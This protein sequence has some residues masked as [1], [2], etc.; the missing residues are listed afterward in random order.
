MRI[1]LSG[2]SGFIGSALKEQ[3]R[4]HTVVPLVR[5]APEGDEIPWNPELGK[6]D[7]AAI[8]G[9]DAFINL[10]GHDVSAGRW[11]A[12]QK[13]LIRESRT[14]TTA[15]LAGTAARLSSPPKVLIN[16]S[17]IGYYGSRGAEELTEESA[18]GT[19]FLAGVCREWEEAARVFPGRL[20]LP[21]FSV[22]LHRSG[23]ALRKMLFPFRL[24]LGGVIGDGNQYL[25]WISLSDTVRVV[26][27]CLANEKLSGPINMAAPEPVMNREFTA[28][29]GKV[30]RRPTI[31]PLPAFG[32]RAM[33]GEMGEETI[34]SSIRAL[35]RKLIDNGFEFEERVLEG[36][37]E[38]AV[39]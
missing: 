26:E 2:G 34:L 23:G 13:R 28:V 11:T 37:L 8:E 24:G 7:P 31:L 6:I 12:T 14:K 27:Y 30:L 16:A 15:L 20:V 3:L 22:V 39:A 5:R 4:S 38:R 21:R 9:F 18:S 32:V 19:G 1:L 17:A 25:S 33:F 36:A 10:S 29:L 35:P